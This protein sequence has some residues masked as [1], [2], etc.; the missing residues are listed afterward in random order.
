[1][2]YDLYLFPRGVASRADFERYFGGRRRYTLDG[3]GGAAYENPATGV[4][5]SFSYL[6]PASAAD[7][8]AEIEATPEYADDVEW[9]AHRESASILF[10]MN[11]CRPHVFGVEA[12]DE[13]A[14][15]VEALHC[16]I[17]DDQ[18]DGMGRGPF[19]RDGFLKGWNAG[20]RLGYRIF[21]LD[22]PEAAGAAELQGAAEQH[23]MLIAPSQRIA[24][25][26]VWNSR[27][28]QV[29]DLLA[30]RGLD[31]FVP[32]VSWGRAARSGDVITFAVWGPDIPTVMPNEASHVLVTLGAK[33]S[34]LLARLGLGRRKDAQRC[35]LVDRVRLLAMA[36]V[37]RVK[38]GGRV[39]EYCPVG[40]GAFDDAFYA[41]LSRGTPADDPQ[42]LLRI[43]SSGGVLDADIFEA[44]AP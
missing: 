4:Y 42:S 31:V 17:E 43:V 23:G 21:R 8:A 28:E 38:A 33:P 44:L 24:D 20:N 6:P 37:E 12:V 30:Q 3:D 11:Y 2:S 41:G 5:F 26:W 7:I 9:R 18:I 1:M 19:T 32:R 25:V 15:V 16:D 13:V 22:A 27:I 29:Q 35:L 36:P 39:I 10:N 40:G 34:G 14:A